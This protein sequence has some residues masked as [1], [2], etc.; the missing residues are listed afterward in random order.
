ME[1]KMKIYTNSLLHISADRQ[2]LRG[3][4][5]DY[6]FNI[7]NETQSN[8]KVTSLLVGVV[9]SSFVQHNKCPVLECHK[10]VYCFIYLKLLVALHPSFLIPCFDGCLKMLVTSYIQ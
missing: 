10:V 7:S 5:G 8:L 3:L 1:F 4:P 2:C 9:V 6:L